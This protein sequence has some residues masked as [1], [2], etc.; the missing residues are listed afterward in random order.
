M[1]RFAPLIVTVPAPDAWVKVPAPVV[2]KFPATLRV[3]PP[4]AVM[5]AP[6][7]A[8]LL[9]LLAPAPLMSAPGPLKLAELVAPANVPAFDQLP[10]KECVKAPPLKVVEEPS[11]TLPRTVMAAPAVK[12]TDVPTPTALVRFPAM[13]K[14]VTGI[15]LTAAPLLLLSVRL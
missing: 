8:T 14:A 15:V 5:P 1:T 2:E 3:V 7:K 4:D 10:P 9:K 12:E 6:L 11:T 13:V